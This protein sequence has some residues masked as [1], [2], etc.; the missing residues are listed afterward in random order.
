MKI[1]FSPMGTIA[2]IRYPGQGLID[3]KATGF[4][5]VVYEGR[6]AIKEEEFRYLNKYR[7]YAEA[8]KRPFL[9]DEPAAFNERMKAFSDELVK[10]DL[11]APVMYAP[12]IE[13][14][15][16]NQDCNEA[17]KKLSEESVKLAVSS[18]CDSV[19]VRPLFIEIPLKDEW[20]VN[21]EFYLS[22]YQ[23]VKGTGTKILLQNQCKDSEGHLVRGMMASAEEARAWVT[24][25]NNETGS[26]SFGFCLDIGVCNLC[27]VDIYEIITTLGDLIDAV[28]LRDNNGH[29]EESLIPF[30]I[31]EKGG[32]TTDWLSVIRGLR[33]ISF[34]KTIILDVGS[35]MKA[36]SPLIRPQYMKFARETLDFIIWQ[37]GIENQ[38]KKYKNIVLFGAGNMCRNY[39]INYG[40]KYPPLYT[41]D[42]NSSRWGSDFFGL[43]IHNPEDLK[44]LDEDTGIFICNMYYRDIRDQL[45]KMGVKAGIEY[46]NDEYLPSINMKYIRGI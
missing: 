24:D 31:S 21:R 17:Y 35:S 11:K 12:V 46:F 25:L 1:L 10:R 3:A 40:D 38:L 20:E 44:E 23:Y 26:D 37:F 5:N 2:D 13:R 16:K 6:L 28:I 34:D 19:I 45:E 14:D 36:V 22:L 33:E 32:P 41:C 8:E 18:N 42:N 4:S 15:V 43:T 7:K 30:T 27:G 29:S 9:V 39:L